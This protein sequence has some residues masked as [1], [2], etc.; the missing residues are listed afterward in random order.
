MLYKYQY[1]RK[2]SLHRLQKHLLFFFRKIRIVQ[3]NTVFKI[4]GDYFLPEFSKILNASPTLAEKFKLFFNSYKKISS[5]QKQ[6]FYQKVEKCQCVR[7]F[8]EDITID[9][10]D[11]SKKSIQKLMHDDTLYELMQ[12]LSKTTLKSSKWNIDGHYRQMYANMP[13]DKMDEFP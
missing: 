13:I 1:I 11:I 12:Y 5:T 7:C 9:C 3:Y 4:D 2:H 6:L 10:S 8:F